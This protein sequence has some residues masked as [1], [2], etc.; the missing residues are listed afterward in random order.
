MI[1]SELSEVGAAALT[2]THEVFYSDY[3]SCAFKKN[4]LQFAKFFAR[5][6]YMSSLSEVLKQLFAKTKLSSHRLA[7]TL[8]MPTPTIHRLL[9][10]VVQDPKI[11]TLTL[12]SDY[13]HIT[14]EQILGRAPL[15]DIIMKPFFSVP[16]LTMNQACS[17]E[18]HMRKPGR[19]Y[20][21]QAQ[22]DNNAEKVFSIKIDN[23][24]YEPIF[25]AGSHL[26][27]KT[28]IEPSNGD[29]VLVSF[30]GDTTPVIKKYI[31]EGRHKYLSAL[32][33]DLKPVSL[34]P[35]ELTVLGVVI[36]SNKCF[37]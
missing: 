7:Q 23:N 19:W 21:W 5:G 26:I 36:E 18:K 1:R 9:T 17:Y 4:L 2:R 30:V 12:L 27:V 20:R 31:A 29:Y 25:L 16:L 34:D 15:P 32:T 6:F 28:D 13:F 37:Y 35:S 14:I 22:S 8:G 11:S 3:D 33:S 24:L 10:G